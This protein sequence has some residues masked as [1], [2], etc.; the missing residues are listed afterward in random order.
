MCPEARAD[1]VLEFDHL[2]SRRVAVRSSFC[3]ED[4]SHRSYAGVF[5]SFLNIDATQLFDAVDRCWQSSK[6]ARA[7]AYA[8]KNASTSAHPGEFAVVVQELVYATVSGTCLS[9]HPITG[10]EALIYVEAVL[11]MGESQ[12]AGLV[13]PDY[14][15][16]HKSNLDVTEQRV[17]PQRRKLVPSLDSAAGLEWVDVPE[18]VA[19][20][21]KLSSELLAEI[22]RTILRLEQTLRHSCGLEWASDDVG[23]RVLQCRAM[24]S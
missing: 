3:D 22:G 14:Y 11:G 4:G 2:N 20:A 17:V 13:T 10:D 16:L 1:V 9:K 21:P 7:H 6:T 24:T 18:P 19:T 5:E 15:V 8:K 12:A 23:L